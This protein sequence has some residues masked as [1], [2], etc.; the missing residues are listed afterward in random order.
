MEL[1]QALNENIEIGTATM[2]FHSRQI[3]LSFWMFKQINNRIKFYTSIYKP[4]KVITLMP[5][6]MDICNKLH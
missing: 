6:S 1:K 3:C 4:K 5:I 2:F